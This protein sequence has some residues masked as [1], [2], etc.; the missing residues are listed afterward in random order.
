MCW[1]VD[2]GFWY[3]YYEEM[4]LSDMILNDYI[5]HDVERYAYNNGKTR[6]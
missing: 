6:P 5:S 4:K 2:N 3:G 1:E